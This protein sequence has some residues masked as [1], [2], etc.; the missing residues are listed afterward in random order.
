MG[1]ASS[2]ARLCMLTRRK[3]DVEARLMR[4]SN[5]KMALARDSEKV[6]KEY[7][8]AL[9][10]TS[11]VYNT[12]A[13]D[14]PLT[15]S[16]IMSPS[17]Q[18]M[19][20]N[21]AG[22]VVLDDTLAGKLGLPGNSGQGTPSVSALDFVNNMTNAKP[23]YTSLSDFTGAD[24]KDTNNTS[25]IDLSKIP[26]YSDADILS[27]LPRTNCFVDT[28]LEDKERDSGVGYDTPFAFYTTQDK[29]TPLR[30]NDVYTQ[31]AGTS[32]SPLNI[33]IN[34]AK[35]AL[36]STF[37]NI[38]QKALET[39]LSTAEEQT[40]DFYFTQCDPKNIQ[41]CDDGDRD[42]PDVIASAKG[43]NQIWCEADGKNDLYIDPQQV[44]ATFLRY[45]EAACKGKTDFTDTTKTLNSNPVKINLGKQDAGSDV[46]YG[47]RG[48][49][50]GNNKTTSTI[51]PP[52]GAP[53][54][55]R[56][57]GGNTGTTGTGATSGASGA[58]D[59]SN[60]TPTGA[61]IY[62]Y[63]LYKAVCNRGWVKDTDIT[64]Q[65]YMQGMIQFGG[66]GVK[67]YQ[68]GDW[69][70][71]SQNSPD[72]PISATTNDEARE[73]AKAAYDAAKD[74][75]KA[76]EVEWDV[77]QTSADTERAAIVADMDSVKKILD[78]NMDSFKLFQQG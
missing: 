44:V 48:D 21:A 4:V 60:T 24:N 52:P 17:T 34:D 8:R 1:L 51:T 65:D 54:A 15:Y 20:T 5:A 71:L 40:L 68:N 69:V 64:N 32:S 58:S 47:N 33:I 2:Q 18:C 16:L 6:S 22:A 26:G 77:E 61:A 30:Q 46:K 56:R 39:A 72:S 70:E 42:N 37:A 73:K 3:A 29:D 10:A 45:F 25:K 43:S 59:A 50:N 55:A 63:N 66:Y 67:K 53:P 19:L 14:V 23:A 9:N 57:P 11:L 76:K 75:I 35:T 49:K 13:K 38:D 78:K 36:R 62:Y 74:K 12:G 27:K 41:R 28:Y 7:T 31:L